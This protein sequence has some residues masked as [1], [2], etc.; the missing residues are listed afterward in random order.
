MV[1]V[2]TCACSQAASLGGIITRRQPSHGS[3][4]S[5]CADA[6]KRQTHFQKL[7]S[8]VKDERQVTDVEQEG[9][10]SPRQLASLQHQKACDESR[11]IDFSDPSGSTQQQKS[12]AGHVSGSWDPEGNSEEVAFVVKI[13]KKSCCLETVGRDG[14]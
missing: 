1:F 2:C 11:L 14:Q 8:Q 4:S 5:H 3:N 7:F 6:V 9:N 10:P 13:E 12:A